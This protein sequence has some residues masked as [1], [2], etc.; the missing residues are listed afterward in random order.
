MGVRNELYYCKKSHRLKAI[1]T[2]SVYVIKGRF[3]TELGSFLQ[4]SLRNLPL[5]WSVF[6]YFSGNEKKV[7]ISNKLWQHIEGKSIPVSKI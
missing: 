7:S 4:D 2:L 1:P 3:M 5:F 6:L